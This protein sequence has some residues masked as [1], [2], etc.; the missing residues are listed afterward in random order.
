[1]FPCRSPDLRCEEDVEKRKKGK[2]EEK[3]KKVL[4]GVIGASEWWMVAN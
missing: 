1:M 2:K 4:T 3:R